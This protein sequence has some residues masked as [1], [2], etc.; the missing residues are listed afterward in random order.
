MA[1]YSID[2]CGIARHELAPHTKRCTTNCGI[3]EAGSLV[4]AAEPL[5][6]AYISLILQDVAHRCTGPMEVASA[7]ASP[8]NGPDRATASRR[9]PPSPK[10]TLLY[11]NKRHTSKENGQIRRHK[12]Q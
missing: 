9:A 5:F 3:G 6:L 1:R 10:A 8:T 12:N 7:Q 4:P 2:G 11:S